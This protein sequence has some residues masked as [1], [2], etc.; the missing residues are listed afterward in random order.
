MVFCVAHA[1]LSCDQCS[2]TCG[3][4]FSLITVAMKHGAE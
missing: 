2:V 4:K 1:F 3:H